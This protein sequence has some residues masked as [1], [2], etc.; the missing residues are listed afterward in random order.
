MIR[1]TTLRRFA[2]TIAFGS[3]AAFGGTD[4]ESSSAFEESWYDSGYEYSDGW[5][6]DSYGGSDYYYGWYEDG[7][8][9]S[10]SIAPGIDAGDSLETYLGGSVIY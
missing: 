2:A 9:S 8:T 3:L 5:S 4:C 7:S 6:G 10:F 1:L